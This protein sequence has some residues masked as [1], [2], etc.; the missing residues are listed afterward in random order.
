M[1]QV[2]THVSDGSLGIRVAQSSGGVQETLVLVVLV[3][4]VADLLPNV[5]VIVWVKL[6]L[7]RLIVIVPALPS[8]I[9]PQLIDEARGMVARVTEPETEP[10][11]SDQADVVAFVVN[12]ADTGNV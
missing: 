3:V 10:D 12:D 8:E 9:D 5:A 11:F 2:S 7:A 4:I 6:L 1:I